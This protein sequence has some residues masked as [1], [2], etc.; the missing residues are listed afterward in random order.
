MLLCSIMVTS[1][2]RA[3]FMTI[4]KLFIPSHFKLIKIPLLRHGAHNVLEHLGWQNFYY[5]LIIII[6]LSILFED[7]SIFLVP[8]IN[9]RTIPW[10]ILRRI[11]IE[12]DNVVV[13]V[14]HQLIDCRHC[15]QMARHAVIWVSHI[16]KGAVVISLGCFLR[17][18]W[19]F[20]CE[21]VVLLLQISCFS[22]Y[23]ILIF[24]KSWQ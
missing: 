21:L 17:I 2:F 1:C 8:A 7:S 18:I 10:N 23:L 14:G 20:S 9:R 19:S 4:L 11:F 16:I 24:R 15:H 5:V 3:D 12:I 22:R 13:V 6:G